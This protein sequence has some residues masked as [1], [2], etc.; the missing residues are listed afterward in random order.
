MNVICF[1]AFRLDAVPQLA[2]TG[3]TLH[4]DAASRGQSDPFTLPE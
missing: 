1:I 3:E 4:S 2:L